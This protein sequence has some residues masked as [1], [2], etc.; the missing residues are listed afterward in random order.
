ML[1][2]NHRQ[3]LLLLVQQPLLLDLLLFDHLQQDGVVQQLRP[4]RFWQGEGAQSEPVPATQ[5]WCRADGDG[6]PA[7]GCPTPAL[8]PVGP[9]AQT[10]A[11][12]E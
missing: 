10:A 9:T 1:L 8:A 12:W 6:M 5:V 7:L 2:L 4:A 11:R 3:Q